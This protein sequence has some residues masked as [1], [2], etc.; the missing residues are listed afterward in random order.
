MSQEGRWRC[1]AEEE[2][3]KRREKRRER[4]SEGG[5]GSRS[6]SKKK[7]SPFFSLHFSL[8]FVPTKN[9]AFPPF[10]S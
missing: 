7:N 6:R 9:F 8:F 10:F 2:E 4:V 5:R 1:G 3:E